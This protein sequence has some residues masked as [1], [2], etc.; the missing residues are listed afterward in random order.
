[1]KITR[2]A[3]LGVAASLVLAACGSDSDDSTEPEAKKDADGKTIVTMWVAG[4]DTSDELRDWLKENFEEE[5]EDAVL[6]IEEQDWNG[7]VPKLQTALASGDQTPD[8]VEV[9]NTQAPLFTHAGAFEDLS[10]VYED[11]GGDKLL[12]EF[13]KQGTVDDTVFSVPYYSGARAVFYNEEM[14]DEAGV[15]VPETIDE[16]AEVAEKLQEEFPNASGIEFPGQDWYNGIAW[17]FTAGGEIAVENGD[18]WEGA[19]SSPESLEGLEQLS[20]IFATSTQSPA[21]SDSA[22]PWIPFNEGDAAM[23]SAPTWARWSIDLEECATDDEDD[24]DQEC[25]EGKTSIFPL[26]GNSAGEPA[27]VFAGGS[28]I[29]VGSK[30]PNKDLAKDLLRLIYSE[31]YQTQLAEAGMIPGNTDY[32]DALGDDEYS[33]AAIDAALNAKLTPPAPKWADVEAERIMEDFFQK[34]ASGEDPAKA[35]E[36]TDELLNATLN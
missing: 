35:A 25:N 31:E 22:E 5:H 2:Y 27:P 13:V 7:L 34:I 23:F 11:L 26:P 3:A 32:A 6:E 20:E 19:L 28:N 29:G 33:Q 21:D 18:E 14:F 10:D 4:D 24:W 30:S 15:E 17:I 12:P 36:E 8:L 1:M 9:G 16:F